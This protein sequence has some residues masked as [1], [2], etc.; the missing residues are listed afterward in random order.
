[1]TLEFSS[2]QLL[3]KLEKEIGSYYIFLKSNVTEVVH[4]VNYALVRDDRN[5]V[6]RTNVLIIAV[7]WQISQRIV[8]YPPIP[9][10]LRT[11]LFESK[12][13]MS[14]FLIQY[15]ENHWRKK[16]FSGSLILHNPHTICY[17][18]RPNVYGGLVAHEEDFDKILQPVILNRLSQVF[19]AEMGIPAKWL[20]KTWEQPAVLN[21]PTT[22]PW[23]HIIWGST[24]AATSYRGCLGGAVQSGY[25]SAVHALLILRPQNIGWQDINEI[26][27]AAAV[28]PRH[29]SLKLF[30]S[31][32][33]LYNTS[34]YAGVAGMVYVSYK[35]LK[36]VKRSYFG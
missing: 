36:G 16:G 28:R 9:Q 21:L 11:P 13:M 34:V 24:T 1:M 14:S 10:E 3:S 33:N 17:E 29:S 19:G 22:T 5:N 12:Y 25:R 4:Y 35:L 20:Q 2:E 27:K 15:P 31:S 23:N 8:F 26:G 32:L 30:L 7:P 18:Y 6:F